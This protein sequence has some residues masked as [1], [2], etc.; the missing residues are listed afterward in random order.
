MSRLLNESWLEGLPDN[1]V[2]NME[3]LNNYVVQRICERIRKIGDIGA[4][5]AH[6]L[7]TAIEYAGADFKAIEKEIARIM[8]MNQ[9]EVENGQHDDDHQNGSHSAAT[10]GGAGS[11][12]ICDF[13][14]GT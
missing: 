14:H 4:A 7:K 11:R 12:R 1:I 13:K 3:A 9:Q 5:D 10:G 6:R 2:E 8:G